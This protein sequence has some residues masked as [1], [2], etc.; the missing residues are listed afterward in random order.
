MIGDRVLA[1]DHGTTTGWACGDLGRL[2]GVGHRLNPH[3]GGGRKLEPML[4]AHQKWIKGLIVDFKPTI[5][6]W[7]EFILAPE[8]TAASIEILA[9]LAA[10]TGLTAF[11]AKVPVRKATV[12]QAK[13]ALTG[14]GNASKD[15]MVEA[16]RS[17]YGYK[18]ETDD[19]ADALG[20]WLHTV[21]TLAPGK[22]YKFDPLFLA[23]GLDG[24]D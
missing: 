9:G 6:T 24:V 20:V 15:D 7:E 1:L 2:P 19:E 22:S 3:D 14:R 11:E 21:R 23:G 8:T 10:V 16:A 12:Q 4:A 5:I 17:I 13:I 18:I